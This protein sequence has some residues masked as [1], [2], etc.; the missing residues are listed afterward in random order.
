MHNEKDYFQTVVVT[1]RAEF[2]DANPQDAYERASSEGAVYNV[3]VDYETLTAASLR[4]T[5]NAIE[6]A[7]ECTGV[8]HHNVGIVVYSRTQGKMLYFRG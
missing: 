6:V 1:F 3:P 5:V 4:A 2:D 8:L 7:C